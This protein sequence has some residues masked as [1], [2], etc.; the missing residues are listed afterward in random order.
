ML[1][2]RQAHLAED[3]RQLQQQINTAQQAKLPLLLMQGNAYQQLDLLQQAE[4]RLALLR[5]A[6]LLQVDGYTVRL[7]R[8]RGILQWQYQHSKVQTEWQLLQ[9]Q[10]LLSQQFSQLTQR[11][12]LLQQQGGQ[13]ERLEQKQQ[14]LS[15]LSARQQQLNLALLSQQQRL[16]AQLNQGLQQQR[17]KDIAMLQQ[18]QRHNKES[19]ARVMERLLA[20]RGS[21]VRAVVSRAAVNGEAGL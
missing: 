1:K 2:A 4:Q 17:G 19:M 3:F 21:D 20:Q 7:T 18:L 6:S 15:T 14:Q 5:Q 12:Q 8:L 16:L 13:T 11:M 10:Q 9:Q